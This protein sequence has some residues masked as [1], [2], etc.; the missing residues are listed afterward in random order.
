MTVD[1]QEAAIFAGMIATGTA[2][3]CAAAKAVPVEAAVQ[4]TPIIFPSSPYSL[5]RSGAA[6]A[7]VGG[8][9]SKLTATVAGK[10]ALTSKI[11]VGAKAALASKAIGVALAGKA[12]GAAALATGA[13][14]ATTTTT[15]T[16]APAIGIGVCVVL[17]LVV[18]GKLCGWL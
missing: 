2:I 14:A 8:T 18:P 3:V 4:A 11:A 1:K 5:M 12:T 13:A 17:C 16:L 10:A 9:V 6:A 7:P 15:T